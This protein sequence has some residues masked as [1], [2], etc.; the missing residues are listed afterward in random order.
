[1]GCFKIRIRILKDVFNFYPPRIAKKGRSGVSRAFAK[2]SSSFFMR[3]PA[4]LMGRLTPTMD[5]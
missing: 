2:K 4:A 3:N 1:M 5:E